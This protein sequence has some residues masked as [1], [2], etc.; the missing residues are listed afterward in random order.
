MIDDELHA[1]ELVVR[2]VAALCWEK[3][4]DESTEDSRWIASRYDE[5]KSK[6]SF[7]DSA[8]MARTEWLSRTMGTAI[9]PAA[10]AAIVM[11]RDTATAHVFAKE[12][13]A[14]IWME[15]RTMEE[16]FIARY[17]EADYIEHHPAAPGESGEA[18]QL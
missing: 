16:L 4:R 1:R 12:A 11:D 3:Y 7:D 9:P 10:P 17:V 13:D 15:S 2:I 14:A 18:A 8:R 6:H 5:L